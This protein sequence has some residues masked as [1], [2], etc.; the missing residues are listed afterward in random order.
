[1]TDRV[2]DVILECV[3]KNLSCVRRCISILN[4]MRRRQVEYSSS[5]A[6]FLTRTLVQGRCY[7]KRV[8]ILK[9]IFSHWL[10]VLHLS[11]HHE[12]WKYQNNNIF[13]IIFDLSLKTKLIY[14]YRSCVYMEH[15]SCRQK[16]G[17]KTNHKKDFHCRGKEEKEDWIVVSPCES[18][19]PINFFSAWWP[20][21]EDDEEKT[22]NNTLTLEVE[23]REGWKNLKWS[24]ALSGN[25]CGLLFLV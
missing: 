2:S 22:E 7:L 23:K 24:S 25:S 4:K 20:K 21:N 19:S 12:F 17:K 18:A 13:V 16:F 15:I 11:L 1:M 8:F 5:N 10:T 6:A 14:H 9:V 3:Q